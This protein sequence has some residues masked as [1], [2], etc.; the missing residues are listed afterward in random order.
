[1]TN[2]L[3]TLALLAIIVGFAN[4][5]ESGEPPTVPG[6]YE[7]GPGHIQ[8]STTDLST[9]ERS[10][11][12]LFE[13]VMA[14]TQGLVAATSCSSAAGIYKFNVSAD[15][16]AGDSAV[17]EITVI[18]PGNKSGA[19]VLRATLNSQSEFK[20]LQLSV[21]QFGN[22]SLNSNE[23]TKFL[24]TSSFNEEGTLMTSESSVNVRGINGR[25]DSFQSKVIKDFYI[26]DPNDHHLYD[27]GL[28]EVSKLNF[29]IEKYW[30]RSKSQRDKGVAVRTIFVKDRLTGSSPCRII[31]DGSGGS[32]S[33]KSFVQSG[34]LIVSKETPIV[35]IPAFETF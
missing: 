8:L 21:E 20:G 33:Q 12:A 16:T 27:W 31:M 6:R 11:Y 10:A 4:I 26:T 24:S 34:T 2:K 17:N 30:Q 32:N 29:P 1:M 9:N 19:L 23:I 22:G 15:M 35:P 7:N 28:Q 13:G 18:S 3:N 25:A 5:A 14:A